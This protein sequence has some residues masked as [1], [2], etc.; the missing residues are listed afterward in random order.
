MIGDE[1][2]LIFRDDGILFDIT[3]EDNAISSIQ[4]YVVASMMAYQKR[5]GHLVTTSYNRNIFHFENKGTKLCS[6]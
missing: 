3:D 1:I 5:K 4:S 2:Q 6:D